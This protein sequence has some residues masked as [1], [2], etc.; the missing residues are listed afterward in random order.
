MTSPSQRVLIRLRLE[1]GDTVYT[2]H[3]ARIIAELELAHYYVHGRAVVN[4]QRVVSARIV[5]LDA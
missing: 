1:N 5:P 3:L 4:G 2:R